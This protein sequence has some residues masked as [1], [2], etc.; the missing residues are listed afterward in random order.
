MMQYPKISI[1]TPVYNRVGMIEQTIQSVLGQNYPNLEYIIIDGGS[2][3]GTV[4][5]IRKYANNYSERSVPMG[6]NDDFIAVDSQD[7]TLANGAQ[8]HEVTQPTASTQ[9]SIKWISEKDNGMYHAI[10]KG[11]AMA[12]GEIVAWINSDDM[13]HTGALHIVGLIFAQLPE[14]EWL[15]GTPTLYNAEGR[16]VKTFPIQ[17]W[18]WERFK[19]GDFR[20]LQQESTFFRKSLFDKVGGLNLDYRLAADFEL[21]CK[22]FQHAK[23]YSV[24]TILGGFRQHGEQLS[25]EGKSRY[26][27]EVREICKLHYIDDKIFCKRLHKM[28]CRLIKRNKI[29]YDF[30]SNQW[31]QF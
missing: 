26:E 21:W 12:T 30:V 9:S 17:Y 8:P 7:S 15:T 5:I 11:M 29:Y 28:R 24:D 13:Y 1:I 14:V 19:R 16:C 10:M 2:T 4:D 20:W 3:D 6:S 18:S 25:I 31:Q 23:L 27:D 22:M